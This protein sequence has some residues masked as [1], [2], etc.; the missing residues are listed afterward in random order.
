MRFAI[1]GIIAAALSLCPAIASAAPCAGFTDVDDGSP[2]CASVQ[3]LRNQGITQGC[4]PT[5]FCPDAAVS[6]VQVAAFL[7]RLANATAPGLYGS[8]GALFGHYVFGVGALSTAGEHGGPY[9]AIHRQG[10]TY[11]VPLIT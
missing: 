11:Y 5:A 4:T 2:F 6:R 8:D 10:R 3:W 7:R 9:A 1:R